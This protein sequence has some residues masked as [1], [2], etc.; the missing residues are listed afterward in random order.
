MVIG[1]A[2]LLRVLGFALLGKAEGSLVAT[3][4][5]IGLPIAAAGLALLACAYL[6]AARRT[7]WPP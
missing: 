6:L 3:L 7:T 5:L 1:V 2:G 4:G